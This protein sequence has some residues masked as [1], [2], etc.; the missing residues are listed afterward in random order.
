[1]VNS[2]H[3]CLRPAPSPASPVPPAA[4]GCGASK[5]AVAYEQALKEGSL[6]QSADYANAPAAPTEVDSVILAAEEA[7]SQSNSG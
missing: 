4:Q 2:A 5:N 7:L 1:M 6:R 3:A